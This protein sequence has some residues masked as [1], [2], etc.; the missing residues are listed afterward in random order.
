MLVNGKQHE[1]KI[2]VNP[3]F[4]VINYDD[5]KKPVSITIKWKHFHTLF[6]SNLT[7]TFHMILTTLVFGNPK[8]LS[9]RD[10][11]AKREKIEVKTKDTKKQVEVKKEKGRF[12]IKGKGKHKQSAVSQ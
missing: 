10:R 11:A 1:A 7:G 9:I 2:Q 3:E 12:K 8:K 6:Q 5:N 4:A